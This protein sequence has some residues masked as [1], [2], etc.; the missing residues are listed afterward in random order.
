MAT[1]Q[2]NLFSGEIPRMG[3]TKI[4]D[5][6]ASKAVNSLLL[7]G[8]LRALKNPAQLYYFTGAS[9]TVKWAFYLP[10]KGTY[11]ERWVGFTEDR[12]AFLKGPLTNDAYDRFYLTKTGSAPL[13]TTR[14]RIEAGS[15]EYLLGT[16]GP[17][18]A[19]TATPDGSGTGQT[20]TRAYVYTWVSPYGEEGPTSPPVIATG[21]DDDVWN[22]SGL[23]TSVPDAA[24]RPTG[25]TKRIYRTVT[26]VNATAQYHFVAEIADS[27]S[28]YADSNNTAEVSLNDSCE[29]FYWQPPPATLEGLKAHPAGFLVG[30]TGR[31]IYFSEPY[32]PHAWPPQYAYSTDQ[33]IVG[34]GVFGNTVVVMTEGYPY[35]LNGI[36]PATLRPQKHNASIPCISPDSI[37]EM[38]YGVYYAASDGLQLA[39]AGGIINATEQLLTVD[40]WTQE[41]NLTSLRAAR[42]NDFYIGFYTNTDGFMFAP[43]E[44]NATFTQLRDV[45]D[46]DGIQQD[47]ILGKTIVLSKNNVAEWYPP[48]GAE[49]LYTWRSK[50]FTLPKPANFGVARVQ[51]TDLDP[52]VTDSDLRSV[53]NAERIIYPG[54]PIGA[55][56]IG[57]AKVYPVTYA[58]LYGYRAPLGGP[59]TYELSNSSSLTLALYADGDLVFQ[60]AVTST[61]AFRLPCGYKRTQFEVEITGNVPVSSVKLA[62][63]GKELARI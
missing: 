23:E 61:E 42:Y 40:E 63:T 46:I 43:K 16:P 57:V 32:R 6:A 45:W 41:Y 19:P 36:H 54:R 47:P 60:G 30:F 27:A 31:D 2:L 17:A 22:L 3:D 20:V 4:P 9:G 50:K 11:T 37:V 49:V 24:Q 13:M 26:T 21:K 53:Y 59:V 51:Y 62:S 35:L 39:S 33:D 7:S 1:L 18:T 44:P 28:T 29:S 34:L 58:S 10:Q 55:A 15:S 52:Q 48:D 12:V 5:N 8:D 56:A 25:Y 38:P 14:D